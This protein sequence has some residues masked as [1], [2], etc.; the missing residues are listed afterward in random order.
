M[1]RTSQSP[2]HCGGQK[3]R[4]DSN[5]CTWREGERGSP[6][7]GEGVPGAWVHWGESWAHPPL[8]DI[9]HSYLHLGMDQGWD[10]LI[11]GESPQSLVRLL[12]PGCTLRVSCSSLSVRLCVGGVVWCGVWSRVQHTTRAWIYIHQV[13]DPPLKVRWTQNTKSGLRLKPLQTSSSFCL[14]VQ[15]SFFLRKY[16]L[17]SEWCL[18]GQLPAHH[19]F[20]H[21]AWVNIEEEE[22]W[23]DILKI[24]FFR[25]PG[26]MLIVVYWIS[27][28][29]CFFFLYKMLLPEVLAL[30]NSFFCN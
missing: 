3:K 21:P 30:H 2:P 24:I 5:E 14:F 19:Y 10:F 17:L 1:N 26:I 15:G 4:L 12:R 27:F 7:V 11:L 29:Q 25:T 8:G 16:Q 20:S 23:F 6:W 18:T 13:T 28:I 22:K 9:A